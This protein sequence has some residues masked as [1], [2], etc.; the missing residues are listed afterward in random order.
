MEE[1]GVLVTYHRFPGTVIIFQTEVIIQVSIT[2]VTSP[3]FPNLKWQVSQL[4]NMSPTTKGTTISIY[5]LRAEND[6][7]Y[8]NISKLLFFKLD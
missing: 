7:C 2:K 6:N 3:V 8:L 5:T 1:V 4:E